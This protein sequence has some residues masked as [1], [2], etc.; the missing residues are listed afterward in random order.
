MCN[1]C[2]HRPVCSRFTATGGYR[3][4]C[5]DYQKIVYGRWVP[6]PSKVVDRWYECSVC[7]T[8]GSPRWRCCPVCEARMY[9]SKN[10]TKEVMYET[11]I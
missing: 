3:E 6:V 1:S 4:R 11:E 8:A 2:I 5:E 7:H 9:K 10:R